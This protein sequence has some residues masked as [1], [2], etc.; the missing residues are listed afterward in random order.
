MK[1]GLGREL[2]E[3]MRNDGG[4]IYKGRSRGQTHS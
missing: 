4:T 3:P 2:C 1:Q